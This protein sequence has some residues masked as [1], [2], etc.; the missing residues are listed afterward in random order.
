VKKFVVVPH[1]ELTYSVTIEQRR[2][3][4]VAAMAIHMKKHLTIVIKLGIS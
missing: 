2:E 3:D 4:F 1:K